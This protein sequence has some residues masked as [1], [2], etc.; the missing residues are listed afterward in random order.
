[1]WKGKTSTPETHYF[2]T[3]ARNS[4]V[5][6]L[7]NLSIGEQEESKESKNSEFRQRLKKSLTLRKILAIR[8]T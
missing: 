5:E 8:N 6:R 1:M 3:W 4:R 7:Y 2:L